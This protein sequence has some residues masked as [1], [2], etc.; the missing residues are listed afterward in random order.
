MALRPFEPRDLAPVMALVSS[1]FQQVFTEDMY[2]ALQQ[3]WPEGQVIDVEGGRLAGVLL[4]MRRSATVGRVLVM[5]VGEGYRDMGIGSLMLRAFIQQCIREGIS[6]IV[7]E[8]RVS[9]VRAQA[10]YRRFGFRTVEPLVA[11]Y[12]DGEDGVL[13]TLDIA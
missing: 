2:L 4:S 12:P 11:Y 9:N 10:F 6:S 13:M 1:T 8:V 7:L 5:A 3:V